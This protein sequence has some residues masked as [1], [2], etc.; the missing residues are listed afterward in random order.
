MYCIYLSPSQFPSILC[1]KIDHSLDF[2]CN[3]NKNVL[4]LGK[5]KK[6]ENAIREKIKE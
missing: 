1:Y 2:I 5:I 6:Q 4:V 3:A